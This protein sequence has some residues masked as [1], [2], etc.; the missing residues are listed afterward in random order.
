MGVK[1]EHTAG[2]QNKDFFQ[3]AYLMVMSAGALATTKVKIAKI[4][5][6]VHRNFRPFV[7]T[8]GKV[9]KGL[10]FMWFVMYFKWD[11]FSS[12]LKRSISPSAMFWF[13]NIL[14]RQ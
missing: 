7:H 3:K 10:H 1:I 2:D 13:F 4:Y 5:A 9:L 14:K 6:L 11:L 8:Q 12:H